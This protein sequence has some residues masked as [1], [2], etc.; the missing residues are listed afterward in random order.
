MVRDERGHVYPARQ[1]RLAPDFFFHDQVYR[2]DGE[3]L[4]LPPGE[5]DVTYTRGPEYRIRQRK[6][7]VPE[8]AA[9]E[10]TFQLE[11]WIDMA[12]LG[13]YSGDLAAISGSARRASRRRW[14]CSTSASGRSW[15]S[16]SGGFFIETRLI[17]VFQR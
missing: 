1:K 11:R 8:A 14:R 3:I 12:S 5:F 4:L 16:H 7:T 9:H 10:E 13:W 15:R 17:S 6:I 2:H